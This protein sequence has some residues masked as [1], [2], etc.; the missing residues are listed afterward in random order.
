[1]EMLRGIKRSVDPTG[2]IAIES[3]AGTFDC[4]LIEGGKC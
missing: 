1:M 4:G 3:G 2:P